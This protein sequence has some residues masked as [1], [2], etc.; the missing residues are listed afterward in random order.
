M[1]NDALVL[2]AAG[3]LL[4]SVNAS[5]GAEQ[6][7]SSSFF[8]RTRKSQAEKNEMK[9]ILQEL[10]SP[11][12]E[13]SL[14]GSKTP[15]ADGTPLAEGQEEEDELPSPPIVPPVF[16]KGNLIGGVQRIQTPPSPPKI[17]SVP[18]I[19]RAPVRRQY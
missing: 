15:P 8:A 9:K 19:P 18:K 11:G 5:W 7:G 17:P 6:K 1:K 2:V 3:A 14:G 13:I 10:P 16:N 4:L 12:P